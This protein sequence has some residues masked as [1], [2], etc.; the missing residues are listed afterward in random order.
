M[1]WGIAVSHTHIII[2][3]CRSSCGIRRKA[4]LPEDVGGA[5]AVRQ[6]LTGEDQPL[7]G[8]RRM[9]RVLLAQALLDVSDGS[10]QRYRQ[11]QWCLSFGRGRLDDEVDL[12][13]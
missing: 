7:I 4:H 10:I 13:G 9:I 11:A 2:W 8:R 12:G 1:W 6:K 5:R 3:Q